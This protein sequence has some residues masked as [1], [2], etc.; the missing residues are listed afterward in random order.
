M[1]HILAECKKLAQCQYKNWRHDKV[2]QAL[3]E[4]R[5]HKNEHKQRFSSFLCKRR[6]SHCSE[7]RLNNTQKNS[8][9]VTS[10]FLAKAREN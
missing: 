6:R 9:Q 8:P 2:A 5:L 10:L 4:R 3:M 1:A 7:T